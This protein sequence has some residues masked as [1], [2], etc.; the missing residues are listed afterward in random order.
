MGCTATRMVVYER[1]SAKRS[2][3]PRLVRSRRGGCTMRKLSFVLMVSCA[4]GWQPVD[5]LAA[6]PLSVPV[7][8][9][10]DSFF[11]CADASNVSALAYEIA[12]P[13]AVNT[14]TLDIAC[15]AYGSGA[16]TGN[17]GVQDDGMVTIET[18]WSYPDAAGCPA[19][20]G[21]PF[22]QR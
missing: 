20:P 4:I 3:P 11:A 10:F 6:C 8:H 22:P 21:F 13:L 5:T 12:D 15:E 16:C 14:G 1:A 9:A 17:S 18:D 19:L 7:V 2:P